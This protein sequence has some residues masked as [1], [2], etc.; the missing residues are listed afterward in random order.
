LACT[1]GDEACPVALKM[2]PG[3]TSIVAHGS[4][5]GARPDAYFKFAARA[6]QKLTIH[7]VG[8]DIKTGPG[9][10]IAFPNGSGDAVDVDTPYALPATGDYVILLHANT[11]SD[12]PFG[13]FVLTL[14]ID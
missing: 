5:S 4:V 3:A 14:R 1:P 13:P 10:P 8:G 9:I 2:S 7:I 11:M 12:G 6:G